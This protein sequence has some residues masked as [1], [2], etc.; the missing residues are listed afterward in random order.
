MGL[1]SSGGVTVNCKLQAR[2]SSRPILSQPRDHDSKRACAVARAEKIQHAYLTGNWPA[3]K[4]RYG[5][6]DRWPVDEHTGSGTLWLPWG[7]LVGTPVLGV[8]MQRKVLTGPFPTLEPY[9]ESL[10]LSRVV[11][12]DAVPANALGTVR[13]SQPVIC[14]RNRHGL[15]RH[16]VVAVGPRCLRRRQKSYLSVTALSGCP[17]PGDAPTC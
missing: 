9:H 17:L 15:R 2:A 8:P 16:Q 1:T 12:L 10:D 4:L 3:A 5:L 11:I 7:Q 6:V 14:L 13:V